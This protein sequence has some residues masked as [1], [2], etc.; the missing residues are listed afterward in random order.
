M[1]FERWMKEFTTMGLT[2]SRQNRWKKHLT[3]NLKCLIVTET[4]YQ[5][6][7]ERKMVNFMLS[8]T[9]VKMKWSKCLEHGKK[10]NLSPR[11]DSNLWP[12]KHRAGA[13]FTWAT[14]NS[15]RARPYTRFISDTRPADEPSIIILAL[16]KSPV[17][18]VNRAPAGCLGGQR[19]ESCRGVRRSLVPRSWH[20]DHFIFTFFS[21]NLKFTIFY[22]FTTHCDID[23]ADPSG[24]QDACQIYKKMY[25]A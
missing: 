14:K 4:S 20:A 6:V 5:M 7:K 8:E 13:L 10:K 19:F 18:Q 11:Q 1:A 22:S 25:M 2:V 23:I 24:M 21:P 17:A 12:P 3:V 15:W 16:H 9:N